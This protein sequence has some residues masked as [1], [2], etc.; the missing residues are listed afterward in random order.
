[1]NLRCFL[2]AQRFVHREHHTGRIQQNSR[3]NQAQLDP[4]GYIHK[5][6]LLCFPNQPSRV[7]ELIDHGE[8]D[9]N[10]DQRLINNGP[11]RNERLLIGPLH[12]D[13]RQI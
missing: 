5:G 4:E 7:I 10:T 6:P 2:L 3:S 11:G 9:N 13:I 8:Y 1:M 12:T